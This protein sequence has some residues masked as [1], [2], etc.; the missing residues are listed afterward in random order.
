MSKSLGNV[1]NPHDLI[2]QYGVDYVRY[3]FLSEIVFGNDGDF[4]HDTF[5]E[6]INADLAD[7]IGNLLMRTVSLITKHC[8]GHI[9]IA[10]DDGKMMMMQFTAEDEEL[11]NYSQSIHDKLYIAL[12]QYQL[13]T[14][15]ELIVSISK[16]GN[17]YIVCQEPWSLMKKGEVAR[18]R[19][20]LFVL[21]E[22][23]RHVGI[24]L[25]PI[26]PQSSKLILDQLG[27]PVQY[28]TFPS[29][30]VSLATSNEVLTVLTPTPIFPKLFDPNVAANLVANPSGKN[31]SKANKKS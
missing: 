18:M 6:K 22:T 20:V 12:E 13:K 27:I 25:N 29:T 11:L 2:A 15:C 17:K 8:N 1:I 24:Y 5:R 28:R 26:M 31:K 4:A 7:D 21:V 19:T 10:L 16:L 30:Q 3:F 9:P 23:L 14:I